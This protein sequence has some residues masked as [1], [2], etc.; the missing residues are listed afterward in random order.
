[1]KNHQN[2]QKEMEME[3][4]MQKHW[5]LSMVLV[6]KEAG[7]DGSSSLQGDREPVACHSH[8][9]GPSVSSAGAG[10][11]WC[12]QAVLGV[13]QQGF[14]S[15]HCLGRVKAYLRWN[16]CQEAAIPSLLGTRS[17]L[18]LKYPKWVFL[19]CE[20]VYTRIMF[21]RSEKHLQ[22]KLKQ[23]NLPWPLDHR[24]VPTIT[25]QRPDSPTIFSQ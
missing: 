23:G 15:R 14:G 21:N 7:A 10:R 11:L 4:G 20:S 6:G 5:L 17:H 16:R 22:V 19:L 12:L 13:L 18:L 3:S 8:V 2:L 9:K 24:R 1:M 25:D